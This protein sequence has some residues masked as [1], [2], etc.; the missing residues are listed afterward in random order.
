VTAAPPHPARPQ[1]HALAQRLRAGLVA[2][3]QGHEDAGPDDAPQTAGRLLTRFV[4][5]VRSSGSRPELWLL[6]TLAAGAFPDS[7]TVLRAERRLRVS[8]SQE[9]AS[10]VL[11]TL[12]AS[13]PRTQDRDVHAVVVTEQVVVDVDFCATNEHH[14]GIQRVVRETLPHWR[15]HHPLT[16]VAWWEDRACYRRLHPD[17]QER[18][19]DWRTRAPSEPAAVTAPDALVVPF[20]CRLVLP[21]T[22]D[23]SRSAALAALAQ[24]S[25]SQVGMIGYDCIPLV[26]PELVHPGLPDRF[27]QYL[28]VVKHAHHV[29]GISDAATNEFAGFRDMLVAQGL[30][31][32]AVTSVP[33]PAEASTPRPHDV[34]GAGDD[35]PLVLSIGSFEPRKNQLTVLVAAEE[36]WRQGHRFRLR[37]IGGGG[38]P[39]EFD[40]VL[41]KVR[42]AGRSVEVRVRVSEE[43]LRRSYAEARFTVFVSLHEGY[44]LP[45]TESLA[46][47]APVLTSGYGST[48]EIADAGGCLVVDP[49]DP[50]AVREQLLRMLTDDELLARL[51]AQAAERDGRGWDDYAHE[52]WSALVAP[53]GASDRVPEPAR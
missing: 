5:R 31:G 3:G 11:Q 44:G 7:A 10:F 34:H 22:P 43:E 46:H 14:T 24:H 6:L 16:L 27:M 47:G 26:S 39:T 28:A 35:E 1:V 4:D 13:L 2:L 40:A 23:A 15:H 49:R 21:E 37:F 20:R 29:A 17:E 32:P 33:L 19:L 42:A 25:G 51:R 30:P 18:V 52:A 41:A 38:Y 36:L 12:L 45:V 8:G 48:A 53:H 50:A 9:S